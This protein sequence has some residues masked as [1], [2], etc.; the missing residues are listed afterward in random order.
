MKTPKTWGRL[1]LIV[2]LSLAAGLFYL[3][4][5]HRNHPAHIT[6]HLLM[7]I[8]QRPL[9]FEPNEGRTAAS[10]K[11]LARGD[12]Y[13]LLLAPTEVTL[14]LRGS[15]AER[16]QQGGTAQQSAPDQS[17]VASVKI[18]LLGARASSPLR[19]EQELPGKSHYFSG[20][21][22]KAWRTNLPTYQRVKY[23]QVYDGIDWV[24]YGNQQQLEYD[25]VVAPGADPNTI[26]LR[27]EGAEKLTL[28]ESGDLLLTINGQELRQHKPVLYQEQQGQRR[29]ITG[30]YVLYDDS[31]VGFAVG[32]YDPQ[33]PLVIDPVLSY[34]S[35]LGGSSQDVATS[36]ALDALGNIY[37]T[38]YTTS[39]DFPTKNPLQP[40]INNAN[41]NDVF[42]VK[43][44]S[45]GSSLLYST[46]LGGSKN[47]NGFAIA[48]DSVG[49][50]YITGQT[51]ST[52]F[53]M[54]N[55]LQGT[56]Q[57]KNDVFVAK[58][59]PDGSA[60]TYSTYLGGS[61][62]DQGRGIAADASGNAV[63]TG[64]TRS[65]NFRT[66]NAFQSTYGGGNIF[67]GDAFVA[68]IN[69]S[70]SSLLFSTFLGGSDGDEGGN[71]ITLDQ[72][73]N[74]YVVGATA[75]ANFPTVNA[76]QPIIGGGNCGGTQFFPCADVFVV[77]MPPTGANLTYSTFLGGNSSERGNA[78]AV[79]GSGNVYLTGIT[80]STNYPTMKAFQTTLKGQSNTFLTKLNNQASTILYSTYLGGSSQEAGYG[81][82][83]DASGKAA[84][85][86]QSSSPDYPLK[87]PVKSAIGT[88]KCGDYLCGDAFVAT[89]D[90]NQTGSSSLTFSTYLGGTH[91]DVGYG[92]ALGTAGGI[93]V[94]GLTLAS[95][96]PTVNA[97]QGNFRGANEAFVVIFGDPCVYTVTVQSQA[98]ANSGGNSSVTV[99]APGECSWTA[100]SDVSWLFITSG[101]NGRGN[102]TVEFSVA[103]NS[104][105]TIRTG[106]LVIAG[107]SYSIKQGNL[108]Q[109]IAGRIT[110]SGTGLAGVS[111]TLSGAQSSVTNTDRNG[112]FNFSGV[113]FAGN[114][115]VTPTKANYNFTPAQRTFTNL[116]ADQVADFAATTVVTSVSGASYAPGGVAIESIVS[117]FGIDLATASLPAVAVPLP[118]NLGGTTVMVKD[119]GGLEHLCPLFYVSPL[120]VN[121]QLPAGIAT[122]PASITITNS[123]GINSLGTVQVVSVAPGIFA[124]NQNGQG[125]AAA[126]VFRI[127]ANGTQR[128]EPVAQYDATQKKY[129]PLPLDLGPESDNVF[130]LLFGTGIRARSSLQAVNAWI[131]TTKV[132]VLYAGAQEEY[133]GLDQ[134]N[135]RLPRTLASQGEVEVILIVE[136]S[137][138]NPVRLHFKTPSLVMQV[139]R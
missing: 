1:S 95:D 76:L 87:A 92:I 128:Y 21:D 53:P 96:F 124:A 82:A 29:E 2:C 94:T 99:T 126:S 75:S 16:Q 134:I 113:P 9:Q 116:S 19:G 137:P 123:N 22:P 91:H 74:I 10:V 34:S 37:L 114:Y 78:I 101:S 65:L 44:K 38:G 47:E 15:E 79:D 6:P 122:G 51:D 66:F 49:N 136:G 98:F 45:D 13:Q 109:T 50:A 32:E 41:Q 35:Y 111:V 3:W 31:V 59:N 60:L 107:Q 62:E 58:L 17:P 43:M 77:K 106:N 55:A 48:V 132:E 33:Q 27:F 83:V 93:Y 69:A 12:G 85:T 120:Q 61:E 84:I 129:V 7:A 39:Q 80:S 70:G 40:A 5:I 8:K 20:N 56:L 131:G 23:S 57:G 133:V 102:G 125:V 118:T 28:A 71:G 46:Y 103:A 24:Y 139:A 68:K 105:G 36:I 63:I 127:S 121:F 104:S 25:F 42:V 115:T 64:Q 97:L 26:K 88:M 72:A 110:A 11:F 112:N 90:T 100:T 30:C 18:K 138:T 73:G 89:F 130:L 81:I 14:A 117:A 52:N 135:L 54:V 108:T 4:R 86:G 119:R 67:T